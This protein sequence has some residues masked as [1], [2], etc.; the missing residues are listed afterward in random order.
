MSSRLTQ[1]QITA[2]IA[3]ATEGAKKAGM[4]ITATHIAPDGTIT[5]SCVENGPPEEEIEGNIYVVGF[6]NYVKIGYT[7]NVKN[8]IAAL[9]T[10]I[11][12]KLVLYGTITGSSFEE[13][14]KL[15]ARFSA[16]RLEGEWFL[17]EGELAA[18]IEEGCKP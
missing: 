13:E 17:R 3:E 7:V 2:R 6:D 12:R 8:R 1:E 10:A 14:G 11:P 16:Y 15:H 18:W 4:S 9:Q 5:L